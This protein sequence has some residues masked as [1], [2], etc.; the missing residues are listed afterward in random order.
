MMQTIGN[1]KG[2]RIALPEIGQDIRNYVNWIRA[3]GMDPIVISKQQEALPSSIH[4]EYRD[5]SQFD[6]DYYDGLVL[7]GGIDMNPA[8]YG[9][10]NN[11]T[12]E[13]NDVLDEFQLDILGKF[14]EEKKPVFGICRG[15]QLINVYFGG[16]L[17]QHLATTPRH[18]MSDLTKP[19][20]IHESFACPGS[21]L[22]QIYGPC[23]T[24][25]SAHHQ[26]VD[27]PGEHIV[28]DLYS[29]VDHVVEALHHEELPVYAVQWHPERMCLDNA[30]DDTVEGLLMMNFFADLCVRDKKQR[31]IPAQEADMSGIIGL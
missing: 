11:G 4:R 10:E 3:T 5:Y 31:G 8:R 27:R 14:V 21:W 7:P 30:R 18:R 16:S 19:D 1:M 24:H 17:I 26:A 9:E 28:I 25:N 13:Y 12:E 15:M 29:A 22:E 2:L 23:F 20:I 6:I